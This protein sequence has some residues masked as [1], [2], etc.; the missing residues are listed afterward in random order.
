VCVCACVRA[1]LR[2]CAFGCVCACACVVRAPQ[3]QMCTH[4]ARATCGPANMQP[5]SVSKRRPPWPE[6]PSTTLKHQPA[7]PYPPH[8]AHPHPHLQ[9]ASVDGE[10]RPPLRQG[11]D[12]PAH[13]PSWVLRLPHQPL[14]DGWRS[15]WLRIP[16]GMLNSIFTLRAC[17]APPL[18]SFE[19]AASHQR[20][21]RRQFGACPAFPSA[22][23]S[24]TGAPS[25]RFP[26]A[27]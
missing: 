15:H 12:R 2:A 20:L 18:R 6:G 13:Q 27:I 21:G 1:W 14:P 22:I 26:S 7:L 3:E 10:R 5:A 24:H 9:R 23:S 19:K 16:P 11:C 25:P 17:L 8:T 4:G